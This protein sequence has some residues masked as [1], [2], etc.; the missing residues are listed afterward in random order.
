MTMLIYYGSDW[1]FVLDDK[2]C[3]HSLLDSKFPDL[4]RVGDT[5]VLKGFENGSDGW[6]HL[7]R[8]SL[9]R[10]AGGSGEAD[11][12]EEESS[13]RQ[14]PKVDGAS[15]N[16]DEPSGDDIYSLLD[17]LDLALESELQDLRDLGVGAM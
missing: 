11:S 15:S 10:R 1:Y 12:A 14:E 8:V 16:Q 9:C 4:S 7:R 5:V 2:G 6:P 3:H 13:E 17:R